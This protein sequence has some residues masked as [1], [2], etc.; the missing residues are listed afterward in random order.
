VVILPSSCSSL[1]LSFGN[2]VPSIE[3]GSVGKAVE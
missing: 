3:E 1:T 2:T